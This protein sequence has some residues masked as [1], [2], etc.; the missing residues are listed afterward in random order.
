MMDLLSSNIDNK[1]KKID[2][3][4]SNIDNKFKKIDL[5]SSNIDIEFKK[6]DLLSSNIDNR[7]KK[8]YENK[9]YSMGEKE[10]LE[11]KLLVAGLHIEA[12][13]QESSRPEIEN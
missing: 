13:E 12:L 7:F 4:S 3:L 1:F 10:L 2:L 5:L 11:K 6:I 8:L 9:I